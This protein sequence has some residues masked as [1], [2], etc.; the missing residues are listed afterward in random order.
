VPISGR[1]ESYKYHNSHC[2]SAQQQQQL[3][4]HST[5]NN[6][7]T[8]APAQS[9]RNTYQYTALTTPINP[10][11]H[12]KQQQHL[13][14]H[15]PTTPINPLQQSTA[16]AILTNSQPNDTYQP[17]AT[18]HSN[19]NTYQYTAPTTPINQRATASNSNT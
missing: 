11:H 9:N 6:Y 18:E 15:S 19:S 16:T 3:S 8:I 17:I 1:Q 12:A 14:I 5:N 10:L 7:K 13:P 2:N 4:I